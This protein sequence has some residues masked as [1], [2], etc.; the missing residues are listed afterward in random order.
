MNWYLQVLKKYVVFNGRARRKEYWYFTLFSFVIFF[1]LLLIDLFVTKTIFVLVLIYSL[2]VL[3]PTTGISVRRLHDTGLRGWWLFIYLIPLIGAITLF[4][5]MVSDSQAGTNQYGPPPKSN[6]VEKKGMFR[7]KRMFVRLAAILLLVMLFVIFPKQAPPGKISEFGKYNGYTEDM[8]NGWNR[9]SEYLTMSDGTRLAYDLFLPTKDGVSATGPFPTL[10]KYTP[11]NRTWTVFDGDGNSIQSQWPGAPW[12]SDTALRITRL[13]RG[14]DLRDMVSRNAWLGDILKSGYAV[15][16]VDRPG[17]GASFGNPPAPNDIESIVNELDELLNWI[18]A[19]TWSNGNI[20]MFGDSIQARIQFIAATTGNP[21]LKAILPASTWID[22]YSAVVFPGGVLNENMAEV[23]PQLQIFFYR[24]ATPV[25]NDTDG[26]LLAQARAQR[27]VESGLAEGAGSLTDAPFRDVTTSDGQKVWSD[28]MTLY[29]QLEKINQA[30]VPTYY[31]NGWYDIY[32]RDNFMNYANLSVPKRLLVRPTD[33]S[34]IERPGGDVDYGA[35]AHRW[36]DYWLKG[37]DNG[38]MDEPPIHYYLQGVEEGQNY[39]SADLWPLED[40]EMTRYYFGPDETM[41]KVSINNGTLDLSPPMDPQTFD[42]YTVDYSITTG[43]TPH[44]MGLAFLHKYP[45]M[46]DHD[47]K[48]LTY[49]TPPLATTTNIIGH[50]VVH[51]WLS[52]EAAD[53]DA[54][55]Y[56]EEVDAKGN[57]TYISQGNLRASHRTPGQ[58]PFENFDLPWYN[59]FESELQ[60]IPA[61]EPCELVFDL[62]PTA[63]Q[64]SEGNSIRITIAFAD[65]GNFDTPVLVPPPTLKLL[66]NTSYPTY[67]E[68]PVV[69]NP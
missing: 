27:K 30:G 62:L 13:I 50:S 37:I 18:A 67:V 61:G 51:L 40:Q 55:A 12:F 17:T 23:Y 46:R 33:H 39:Q 2:A 1:A 64:F 65:D 22:N 57:S 19:Q 26:V 32:A 41:E 36:F 44:W 7:R 68:M 53:L 6:L 10:F 25:D 38:I 4:I 31:I 8:Y 35:E 48:A 54:F 3:L 24:M 52:T 56:L 45:N 69:G 58:A 28:D 21:H 16:A 49:T 42:S 59:H 11:Y 14:S 47:T 63:Y 9:T 34:N 5:Y 15:I 20:G 43:P 66:R 29:P 60:P